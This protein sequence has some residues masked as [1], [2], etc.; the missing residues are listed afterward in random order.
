M[1]EKRAEVIDDKPKITVGVTKSEPIVEDIADSPELDDEDKLSD[2]KQYIKKNKINLNET[3][4]SKGK[5]MELLVNYKKE[6][7]LNKDSIMELHD[8]IVTQHKKH[9]I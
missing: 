5:Y 1:V 4:K 6:K 7:K 9:L 3:I 8:E 2:F